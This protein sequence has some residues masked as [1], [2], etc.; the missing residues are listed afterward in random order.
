MEIPS[1]FLTPLPGEIFALSSQT[2]QFIY[3]LLSQILLS[4]QA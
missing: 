2:L 1:F 4:S 3:P